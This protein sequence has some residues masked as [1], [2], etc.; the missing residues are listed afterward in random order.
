MTLRVFIIDDEPLARERIRLLLRDEPDVEI[1]GDFGCGADALAAYSRQRPDLMFV[2]VQMPEMTGFEMLARL[3]QDQ[4]PV[5]VF[6]TAY[7]QHALQ[8][9]EAHALDYLLK[10]FKPVRFKEAV[11]RAR[12]RLAEKQASTAARGLLDLLAANAPAQ[13]GPKHLTRL[14]IRSDDKVV[15][16]KVSD[17]DSIESAGNYVAVWMGK[18]SH[19]LRETLNALEEQLDPE[20]FLRISRGAIVNLDRV[21]ELQPLF[22]GEHVVVLQGGRK[23]TM[24]RGLREVERALR[25]S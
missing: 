9:F 21:R 4:L 24:T 12:G 15:I 16:L 6:A 2:D 1:L 7:D 8:A 3:P 11:E 14:T 25:F 13:P 19:I 5:V 17:I 22:K 18:E 10:P 23:L 20:R